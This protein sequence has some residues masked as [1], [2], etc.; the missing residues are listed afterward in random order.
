[1]SASVP[2]RYRAF[3]DVVRLVAAALNAIAP[4]TPGGFVKATY[5][6]EPGIFADNWPART[7]EHTG[8][9]RRGGSEEVRV[10]DTITFAVRHY[11]PILETGP[12][13]GLKVAQD[14]TLD[15]FDEWLQAAA[16]NSRLTPDARVLALEEPSG[17]TLPV[18]DAASTLYVYECEVRV[19]VH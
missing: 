6:Y 19:R 7:V 13:D 15:A 16:L 14:K 4:V 17:R 9:E 1:M 18:R 2:L 5:D 10:P 3:K 12:Q 8:F 11:Y